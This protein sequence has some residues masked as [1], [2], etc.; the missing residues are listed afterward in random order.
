M[1]QCDELPRALEVVAAVSGPGALL[2]RLLL[3]VSLSDSR[4]P[5][6][7]SDC[8]EKPRQ[9]L[10]SVMDRRAR[11]RPKHVGFQRVVFRNGST[12]R[13][14]QVGI[15]NPPARAVS[16]NLSPV[17]VY[18]RLMPREV[19]Q[20]APRDCSTK[21]SGLLVAISDPVRQP[22]PVRPAGFQLTAPSVLWP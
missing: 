19:P 7:S 22:W 8:K 12:L 14:Q 9:I 16:G 17:I 10:G 4:L 3:L 6:L 20:S 15:G 11:S 2:V 1:L 21:E 18:S 5:H 13:E